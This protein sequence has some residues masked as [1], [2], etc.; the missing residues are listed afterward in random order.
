[1]ATFVWRE[2]AISPTFTTPWLLSV[3]R[4]WGEEAGGVDCHLS[5]RLSTDATLSFVFSPDCH[6]SPSNDSTMMV[7]TRSRLRLAPILLHSREALPKSCHLDLQRVSRD[8][9]YL[10]QAW[11][12]V[13]SSACFDMKVWQ[14]RDLSITVGMPT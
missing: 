8:S 6:C 11:L 7:A 12:A 2:L 14:D 9:Y 13:F 4:A 10:L 1:M 3:G 5:A